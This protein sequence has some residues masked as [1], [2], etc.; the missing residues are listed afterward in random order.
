MIPMMLN[1]AIHKALSF[2]CDIDK[3][4]SSVRYYC[5]KKLQEGVS[6]CSHEKLPICVSTGIKTGK[7]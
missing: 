7:C 6:L 5:S 4:I 2:Y 1:K 3:R